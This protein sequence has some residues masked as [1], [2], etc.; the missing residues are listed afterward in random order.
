M[1]SSF[2]SFPQEAKVKTK[3]KLDKS[4]DNLSMI[5]SSNNVKDIKEFKEGIEKKQRFENLSQSKESKER[6]LKNVLGDKSIDFL[7]SRASEYIDKNTE[8][9]KDLSKDEIESNIKVIDKDIRYK[10]QELTRLEE[11]INNLSAL[12]KPLFDIEEEIIRKTRTKQ[13]YE[14]KLKSLELAKIT[15]NK[16]SKEIQR[17]FAPKLNNKVSDIVDNI[18]NG[19]YSE[20]KITEDLDVK[21]ADPINGRFIEIDKLSGGTIDQLYF[22]TRL[23][24]IDII[25]GENNI[26][27][28]LDDAF[29]QYD[30]NRLENILKY[31]SKEGLKRQIILLTCHTRE[32]QLFDNLGIE[33]NYVDIS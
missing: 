23:G 22:A 20:V 3:I 8:D 17:D 24:I 15:I 33:Y 2:A 9:I 16:I 18:T 12:G 4:N 26:P 32:K 31:I 1:A 5:L 19:K 13:D 11:K 28:I 7:S 10:Y 30:I 25:K 29:T 6:L 14:S 27:L 21:I